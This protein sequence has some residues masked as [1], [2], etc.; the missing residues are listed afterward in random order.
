MLSINTMSVNTL[1]Y[2]FNSSISGRSFAVTIASCNLGNQ[3][4]AMSII[5]V[6]LALLSLFP[7]CLVACRQSDGLPSPSPR[8]VADLIVP[9]VINSMGRPS[10]INFGTW[11]YEGGNIVRGLWEIQDVFPDMDIEAFLHQH[12]NFFQVKPV[13]CVVR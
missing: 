5:S 13:V 2:Q 11:S 3:S 10:H 12:L 8:E 1:S 7:W 6:L 9:E 4:K